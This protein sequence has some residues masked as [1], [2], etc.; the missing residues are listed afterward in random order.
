M[1]WYGCMRRRKIVHKRLL[2]REV[3]RMAS[4]VVRRPRWRGRRFESQEGNRHFGA[5][6]LLPDSWR[7]R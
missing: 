3:R 1:W 4:G 2:T 7:R 6:T 5:R